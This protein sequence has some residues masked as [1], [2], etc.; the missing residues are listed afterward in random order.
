METGPTVSPVTSQEVGERGR[1][2]K[3]YIKDGEMA[4]TSCDTNKKYSRNLCSFTGCGRNGNDAPSTVAAQEPNPTQLTQPPSDPSNLYQESINPVQTPQQSQVY[5]RQAAGHE[6]HVDMKKMPWTQEEKLQALAMR[7]KSPALYDQMRSDG[8]ALPS[9]STI[10]RWLQSINLRPGVCSEII[11]LIR[12]KV[13][14]MGDWEKNAV[15]LFDEMSIKSSL[16]YDS[17]RDVVEGL[18]DLGEDGRKP[19]PATHVLL[20]MARGLTYRWKMPIAY[21]AT[22]KM[23]NGS[24]VA[25]LIPKCINAM[26]DAGL[27]ETANPD[28]EQQAA[29]SE[30]PG[31]KPSIGVADWD[32]VQKLYNIDSGATKSRATKLTE[33]HIRPNSFEKM[34]VKLATQVFSLSVSAAMSTAVETGELPSS[35]LDTAYLLKRLNNR[36]DVMNSTNKFHPNPYKCAISA[37]TNS[38]LRKPLDTLVDDINWVKSLNMLH[39]KKRPPCLHSLEHTLVATRMLWADLEEDG[40]KYLLTGRLNQDPIENEFSVARQKCGFER[41]PSIRL[42]R[43]NL[44]HRIQAALV[45][46]PAGANCEPDD[47]E[48]LSTMTI[49]KETEPHSGSSLACESATTALPTE[50]HENSLTPES[51]TDEENDA[52]LGSSLPSLQSCSVRREL[53]KLPPVHTAD[54]PEEALIRN[55][56]YRHDTYSLIYPTDKTTEVVD[57]VLSVLDKIFKTKIHVVGFKKNVLLKAKQLI[58]K[59]HSEWM[60]GAT[61]CYKHRE[62]LINKIV[63]AK[64][65][66]TLQA[67]SKELRQPGGKYGN[68]WE[69]VMK[70][71][72]N[73]RIFMS[74]RSTFIKGEV[75]IWFDKRTVLSLVASQHPARDPFAKGMFSGFSV[76]STCTSVSSRVDGQSRVGAR[77]GGAVLIRRCIPS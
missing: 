3:C 66:R 12:N 49:D 67:M 27:K 72:N 53:L 76:H 6:A 14:H 64:I 8:F 46:P 39:E 34:S 4:S 13:K 47:D 29:A 77:C 23:V 1:V 70:L 73:K 74:D 54:S 68:H 28:D 16:E 48:L 9:T 50:E 38:H 32:H 44:R 43:Q 22:N 63:S 21:F 55:K 11:G 18:F 10:A 25:K 31:E 60:R 52:G 61:D 41:N 58:F 57:M 30:E 20:F 51:D 19:Y 45:Q 56:E 40:A 62:F 75:G 37:S 7:Y 65:K 24:V 5:D 2:G 36:F 17:K 33:K 26:Q 69:K 42:F 71:Q 35:A 59:T 15:I